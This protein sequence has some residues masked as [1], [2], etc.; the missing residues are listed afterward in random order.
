MSSIAEREARA[1]RCA[2]HLLETMDAEA[3]LEFIRVAIDYSNEHKRRDIAIAWELVQHALLDMLCSDEL[4]CI[5]NGGSKWM[6]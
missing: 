2:E 4:D 6:H 5:T 3:A 1:A